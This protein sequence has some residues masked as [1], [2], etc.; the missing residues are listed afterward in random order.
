MIQRCSLVEHLSN[1]TTFKSVIDDDQFV[2]SS[3]QF[4][5]MCEDFLKDHQSPELVCQGQFFSFQEKRRLLQQVTD[6]SRNVHHFV[7]LVLLFFELLL[8]VSVFVLLTV[9]SDRA[10]T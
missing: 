9:L 5:L 6:F 8:S 7:R 3:E 4:L 1:D 2:M 10:S